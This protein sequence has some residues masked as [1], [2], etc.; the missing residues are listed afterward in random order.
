MLAGVAPW[1][2]FLKT[3]IIAGGKRAGSRLSRNI[4]ETSEVCQDF[5]T[6]IGR[7]FRPMGILCGFPEQG[8]IRHGYL[9]ACTFA[10]DLALKLGE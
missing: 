5:V 10:D 3:P 9:V 7:T 8:S 2:D 6:R 1:A 4:A